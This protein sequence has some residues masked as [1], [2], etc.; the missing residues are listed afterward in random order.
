MRITA[1]AK[2]SILGILAAG[3]LQGAAAQT[4]DLRK[5]ATEATKQANSV[6]LRQLPFND[7]SD[8][9]AANKGFLAPL[10][11]ELIKG[12]AGNAI[13]N[14]QQYSFIRSGAAAPDTV[15]PSLWRQ[16]QLINISGLFEVTDGIYQVRNQDLSNMTIIEGS[17]GITIVD[18]LV[19]AETAKVA[20][21]LYRSK[22]GNKP[23]K[24]VIYTHSHVDHYGGVRGVT[25]EDDVKAGKVKI[26]APDGFLEAAVAENVMAGTAMSRRASYMYGNLLKP[27]PKGQVGAGLGTTTSAGTVTL[28]A[29][30]NIIKETGQ[31]EKIDGL[32]YEFLMAPGSEAPSEMMWFIEEKK[33]ME[34]AEDATHTLHNTYSLRGAKIREPLPWSKY[35]NQALV[36]WGDKVEVIF[37]QHHWPT[38]GKDKSVAFLRSQRDLYRYI[39]DQTLRMVNQGMTMREIADAFKLPD[40]L[41]NV[42]ANRGYYGSVYHD[43][44][45]TYVLY[46]GW[47]DGNP[48]TLHELPP[49]EGSKKY[50]EFMGGADEVLKKAKVAYDKG[51]YRWVSQVVYHV[52]FADPNNQ[53]AKNLEADALEQLGYQAESGPWRNFYLSGAQE[54]RNGVAKL[55][56]PNTASPD[57]VRAM[58]LSLFFDYLGVRLNSGKA[59][60][61]RAKL[62]FDFGQDGNYFVEL[63]NGVLNHTADMKATN[64]D[65]TIMLS[66]DTLNKIVLQETKLDDAIS[67]GAV[68][69]S[70]DQTKLRDVVS[71][72]D[73]FEFWFNIVTP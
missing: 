70:G 47:F 31:K 26:Y 18:P 53:A 45:A 41:G 57:T 44:A 68:K 54:L 11:G 32:T 46:L 14:P 30:T 5:D 63:E 13:W 40:S 29:P 33:A 24:A 50:V 69:I 43:V 27:D 10:P 22:R 37:A 34:A 23:V 60:N 9:D 39:N 16:S 72:L 15:N 7:T 62:N 1:F 38:W 20:L 64:A 6:L 51:E 52:V 67:S 73:T 71:Y 58:S 59:G 21:D 8:F 49:V 61:A 42:W 12:S 65:A 28:I 19:S 3:Y 48:A 56:T 55:P 66:K 36:M 25:S 2:S 17:E 4:Q 35:L